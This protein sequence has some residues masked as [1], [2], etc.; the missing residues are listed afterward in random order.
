M[1]MR[2]KTILWSVSEPA[3]VDLER[4]VFSAPAPF[5]GPREGGVPSGPPRN[6]RRDGPEQGLS[7]A[8]FQ[9][10][11]YDILRFNEGRLGVIVFWYDCM[12]IKSSESSIPLDMD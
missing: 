3:L 6:P 10:N 12:P 1:V 7:Q 4:L 5:F 9:T 11:L 8:G 2:V